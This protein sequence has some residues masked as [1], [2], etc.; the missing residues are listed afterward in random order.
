MP[1][2]LHINLRTRTRETCLCHSNDLMHVF[3]TKLKYHLSFPPHTLKQHLLSSQ[4]RKTTTIMPKAPSTRTKTSSSRKDPLSKPSK[5]KEPESESKPQS[6]KETSN[7][8]DSKKRASRKD[9]GKDSHLYTDDNPSTTLHGTGFK[10]AATANHTLELI[11]KRSLTYQ[12]QTI[13][14]LFHRARNHPS[15]KKAKTSDQAPAG[16]TEALEVF[17]TWLE[18][19]YPASKASLRASG[20]K[21]LLSKGL[22]GK[23]LE[24]I[25]AAA[26]SDNDVIEPEAAAFASLYSSLP[27]NRRLGNV[28]VDD[29]KPG[30]ADWE[31]RRYEALDRL[32]PEGDEDGKGWAED[33]LWDGKGGLSAEHL[34][35]VAWGWSP[36][37]ERG[38]GKVEL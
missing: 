30:E 22:V 35:L 34:N 12:F 7:N 21:P 5:Q 14:T 29:D 23:C 20:F 17:K 1:A 33:R 11:S 25:N 2:D 4:L 3:R 32:V 28:L 36:V 10:D 6:S 13:N 31:V 8:D 9:S 27:K 37:G 16:I 18:E 19:T 26:R 38:L 24:R 15:V